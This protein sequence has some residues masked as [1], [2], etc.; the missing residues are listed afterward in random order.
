MGPPSGAGSGTCHGTQSECKPYP[1]EARSLLPGNWFAF[2]LSE[3]SVIGAVA[4]GSIAQ[5]PPKIANRF[6]FADFQT[7]LIRYAHST[8]LWLVLGL[9]P[10]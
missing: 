8:Q 4:S 2:F 7:L 6:F 1:K 10:D 5:A 3:Y 9:I